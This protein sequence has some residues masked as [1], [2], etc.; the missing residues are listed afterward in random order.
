MKAADPSLPLIL[1]AVDPLTG[2]KKLQR[3]SAWA[4]KALCY[5]KKFQVQPVYGMAHP[6]PGLKGKPRDELFEALCERAQKEFRELIRG[7]RLTE[8]LPLAVVESRGRSVSGAVS[9]VLSYA[10]DARPEMIVSGTRARK[11]PARWF[12]GSFAETLSLESAFPLFLV[13][14]LWKRRAGFKDILFPTDF[15]DPSRRA[16]EEVIAFARAIGGRIH[17][18]HKISHEVAATWDFAFNATAF[19]ADLEREEIVDSR[20]R[21]ESWVKLARES[22]VTA[23]FEIDQLGT[24]YVAEAILKRSEKFPC[25]IAMAAQSGSIEASLLGSIARQVIRRATTPVWIVR[26][27]VPGRPE[28]AGTG[29]AQPRG[30]ARSVE[31]GGYKAG[32]DDALP[33]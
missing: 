29:R 16:F 1:W 26:G 6:R 24:G 7:I 14:P 25:L 17:L 31:V 28:L 27:N 3:E 13:N 22:G 2:E 18:Y 20:A 21:A 4:I 8:L 10:D 33:G 12:L 30:P 5:K 11:G 23:T 9:A 32:Y 19:Y 15:S